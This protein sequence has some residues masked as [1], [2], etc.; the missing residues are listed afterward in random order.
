[1]RSATLAAAL[2]LTLPSGQALALCAGQ[3]PDQQV[4]FEDRF[5]DNAAGWFLDDRDLTNPTIN[6]GVMTIETPAAAVV[7]KRQ[8]VDSLLRAAD[9]CVRFSWPPA[10]ATPGDVPQVGIITHAFL[11]SDDRVTDAQVRAVKKS[12]TLENF[13]VPGVEDHYPRTIA[14]VPE[15]GTGEVI[16]LRIV[17]TRIPR[18]D[19]PKSRY[20]TEKYFIN[21]KEI[22]ES[23]GDN[24]GDYSGAKQAYGIFVTGRPFGKRSFPIRYFNVLSPN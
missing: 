5:A 1:V 10:S 18:D 19:A 13:F 8:I 14:E 4:I 22:K 23:D 3:S 9:I 7:P 12:G 2:L 15:A 11:N 24:V 16:E 20:L 6:N 21:G 17:T